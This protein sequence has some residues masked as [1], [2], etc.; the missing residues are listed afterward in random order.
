MACRETPFPPCNAAPP[1]RSHMHRR[2]PE[3]RR[4]PSAGFFFC[5]PLNSGDRFRLLPDLA[6]AFIVSG[7]VIPGFV[8]RFLSGGQACR[9]CPEVSAA[10]TATCSQEGVPARAAT[11]ARFDR[12]AIPKTVAIGYPFAKRAVGAWLWLHDARSLGSGIGSSW[13]PT[14]T[15]SCPLARVSRP[16]AQVHPRRLSADDSG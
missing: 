7:K 9:H 14:L 6:R 8:G 13:N 12:S 2:I 15:A 16:G 11:G 10:Q 4:L 5:G 3:P 1:P